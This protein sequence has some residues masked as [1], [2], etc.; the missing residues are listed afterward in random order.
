MKEKLLQLPVSGDKLS[1]TFFQGSTALLLAIAPLLYA[2]VIKCRSMLRPPL[3]CVR[4]LVLKL[5][6]K[7][8]QHKKWEPQ[9]LKAD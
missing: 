9:F 1:T 7:P 6:E 4:F 8:G 3:L 2:Q 5:R